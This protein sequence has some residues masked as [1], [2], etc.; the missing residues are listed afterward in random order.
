M[1]TAVP[2]LRV[3]SKPNSHFKLHPG[4]T[5]VE[6]MWEILMF[7][8]HRWWIF[9]CQLRLPCSSF[10]WS[11]TKNTK[12]CLCRSKKNDPC[13]SL[14]ESTN[15]VILC[16]TESVPPLTDA[17]VGFRWVQHWMNDLTSPL[18]PI[19][20]N[21]V[22]RVTWTYLHRWRSTANLKYPAKQMARPYVPPSIL[23]K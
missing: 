18:K 5:T 19:T 7:F 22:V 12:T 9:Q 15:S 10:G 2:M 1:E 8:S 6:N 14:L 11:D 20:W 3:S 4:L 13:P 21:Y 23:K 16:W 17:I